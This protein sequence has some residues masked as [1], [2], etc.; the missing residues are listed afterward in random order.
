VSDAPL[1]F[2]QS[3]LEAIAGALVET[4]DGLIESEIDYIL[5]ICRMSDPTPAL[6]KRH[7]LYNAFAE[8]QNN[9]QDRR[10]ILAFI[11]QAMKPERYVRAPERFEAI[12]ANLNRALMFAGIAVD[13][14]GTLSARDPAGTLSAAE[15]RAR[16]LREDLAARGVHIDVI[17]FCRAEFVADDYF[18]A[19]EEATKSI[20]DKLR[21]HTGLVEDGTALVDRALGGDLPMLAINALSSDSERSEQ[22]AFA[23]LVK[24]AS[25]MFRTPTAQIA[26]VG[27]AINKGD[28][29]DLLCLASLIHR[30]LDAVR[31]R[32]R[33]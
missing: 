26:R 21:A 1:L 33:G 16:Q 28:A 9:R 5:A 20:A 12:R 15:S 30:R 14:T 6:M 7:R 31:I 4:G 2:T 29:E 19:V 23:N 13:G 11:R 27:W 18:R 32:S 17:P 10:A 25:G 22:R 8:S 3:Q 24:G